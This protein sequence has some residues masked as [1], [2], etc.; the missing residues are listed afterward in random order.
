MCVFDD[1]HWA[2]PMFLA[3]VES[4]AELSQEAPILLL[5]MAR[6]ELL[7]LRPSW[8][9]GMWNAATVLLEPLDAAETAQLFTALGGV[10]EGLAVRIA[11]AADGNPLFLEEMLV[12]VRASVDGQVE[13][14]PTIQALLAARLD[15]LEAGER[16]V[17]ERGSVE[18]PVFH[19]GAVEAL[20]NGEPQ[21]ARLIALVRKQLVRPDR[22]QLPGEDAFRFR[23]LLIR[24]AAYDALPKSVR[25]DLHRR[26]AAWLRRTDRISSSSRRS[27]ATTSSRRRDT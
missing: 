24:D 16:V 14:P 9:G 12:L 13:V 5:C 1:L 17:L 15:Q 8:G 4:V 10:E 3:L 22:A 11:A 25:A 27:R 6:P 26:F 23:H 7:E 21:G 20:A 19:R 2:E 18:G